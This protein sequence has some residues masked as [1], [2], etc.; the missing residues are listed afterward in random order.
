MHDLTLLRIDPDFLEQ[1]E[2]EIIFWPQYGSK[3]DKSKFIQSGWKLLKNK[4]QLWDTI[5]WFKQYMEI[6]CQRRQANNQSIPYLF[7]TTRGKTGPASRSVIAGWVKTALLSAGIEAGPGSTRSAV[8]TFRFNNYLS[9]DEVLKK[10]N[11][12][13]PSNFF[14]HYYKEIEKAPIGEVNSVKHI[15]ADS[16]VPL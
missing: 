4:Q 2:E 9:L 6:S 14:K 10:G 1:S 8:A 16:F 5:H 15:I 7:I 13:G 11:W 12:Q 3:T